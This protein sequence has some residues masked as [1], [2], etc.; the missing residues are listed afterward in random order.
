[1]HKRKKRGLTK[2]PQLTNMASR[3]NLIP[4]LRLQLQE[5]LIFADRPAIDNLDKDAQVDDDPYDVEYCVGI[6]GVEWVEDHAL[7]T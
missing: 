1:M 5:S 6:Q 4:F 7:E 2:H 3:P